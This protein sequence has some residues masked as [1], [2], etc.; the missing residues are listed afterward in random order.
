MYRIY[1]ITIARIEQV[2]IRY[3]G[4]V[5]FVKEVMPGPKSPFSPSFIDESNAPETSTWSQILQEVLS[6]APHNNPALA[7]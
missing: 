4:R 1:C 5:Q 3:I 6:D 2:S 7:R